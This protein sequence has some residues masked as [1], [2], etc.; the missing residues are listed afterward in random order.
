MRASGTRPT[1]E[2]IGDGLVKIIQELGLLK[3]EIGQLNEKL[4]PLSDKADKRPQYRT[5]LEWYQGTQTRDPESEIER[6]CIEYRETDNLE[7]PTRAIIATIKQIDGALRD[8]RAIRADM[9]AIKNDSDLRAELKS[10]N[11]WED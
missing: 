8:V 4:K 6:F 7:I 5:G 9:E 11:H 10:K 2:S 1:I 3:S